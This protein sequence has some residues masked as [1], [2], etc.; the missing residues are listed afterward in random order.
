M[1]RRGTK[2]ITCTA[3]RTAALAE[4]RQILDGDPSDTDR[5]YVRALGDAVDTFDEYCVDRSDKIK[6]NRMIRYQLEVVKGISVE[7]AARECGIAD[8]DRLMNSQ[9]AFAPSDI[10]ALSTYFDIDAEQFTK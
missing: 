2:P 3:D 4:M 6:P 1:N 9:R 7:Q 5:E 10:E 8:L